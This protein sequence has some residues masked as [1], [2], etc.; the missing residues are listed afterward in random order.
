MKYLAIAAILAAT[1]LAPA[2]AEEVNGLRTADEFSGIE[3]ET[4]RSQALF[5]EMMKVIS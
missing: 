4:E 3:N 1:P 2:F 5:E